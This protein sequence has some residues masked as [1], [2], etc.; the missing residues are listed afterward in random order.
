MRPTR[1]SDQEDP[2]QQNIVSEVTFGLLI[3]FTGRGLIFHVKVSCDALTVIPVERGARVP[4][5]LRRPCKDRSW[6]EANDLQV[7]WRYTFSDLLDQDCSCALG[8]RVIWDSSCSIEIVNGLG[9]YVHQGLGAKE[10]GQSLSLFRLCEDSAVSLK[11]IPASY[12][13]LS[14]SDD[15]KDG[16]TLRLNWRL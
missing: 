4:S 6:V 13:H 3:T 2:L 12:L 14:C 16:Q 5:L 9:R 15:R 7:V 10:V 1:H 8:S 11:Y